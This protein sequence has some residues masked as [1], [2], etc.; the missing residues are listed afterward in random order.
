GNHRQG[1]GAGAAQILVR[2]V[3]DDLV[4]GVAVDRGHDAAGDAEGIVEDL[5]DRC[6][7]VGGAGGIGDDVVLRRVVLVVIDAEDDGDVLVAGRGR[8]DHLFDGRA[9]VGLGLGGVGEEA[10]RFDNDL[11]A[12]A[13][14]VELGGIALGEDLDLFAVDGDEVIAMLDV[15][16]EIA[17]DGVVFEQVG[18]GGRGSEVVYG[19]EFDFRIVESG[20]EDVAS[21]AAEAVDAYLY[22]HDYGCS[23]RSLT[24]RW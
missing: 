3:E 1:S 14:P 8:D 22:C 19:Y 6:E 24:V 2:R 9:E 20:A 15:V 12:Y 13:G 17:Q 21:D 18:Q 5:D 7:A 11:G 23:Y 10:G 16:L 4:I